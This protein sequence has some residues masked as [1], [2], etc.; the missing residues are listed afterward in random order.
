MSPTATASHLF[1]AAR[2]ACRD[3]GIVFR[4][5]Q[6]DG[7]F[8]TTDIEDDLRGKMMVPFEKETACQNAVIS[9]P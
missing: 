8:Y 2:S 9:L 7:R 4:E 5:V 3:V 6:A 1:D